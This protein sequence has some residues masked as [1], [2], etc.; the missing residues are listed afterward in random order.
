VS[1]RLSGRSED[2]NWFWDQRQRWIAETVGIFGFINRE[3][4]VCK[5]GVSVPQA[6]AD[7]RE[8][9]KRRPGAIIYDK[10]LKRYVLKDGEATEDELRREAFFGD[11]K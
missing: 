3:H 8:F 6:S 10:S 2:M 4:I 5:F 1:G 9:Q 11:P 7:L